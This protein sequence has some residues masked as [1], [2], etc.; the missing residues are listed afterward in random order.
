MVLPDLVE[1]LAELTEAHLAAAIAL[2]ARNVDILAH[3]RADLLFEVQVQLHGSTDLSPEDRERTRV[4]ARRLALAE[5]RLDRTVNSV[6]RVL[7]PNP[8]GPSVYGRQ[9]RMAWR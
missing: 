6:L 3:Q 5:G 4:A 9:G 7:E 2:D 8:R 1:Q